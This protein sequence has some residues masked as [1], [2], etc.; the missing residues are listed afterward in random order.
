MSSR[1][2]K[3]PAP[4][5]K[6]VRQS[7]APRAK[8]KTARKDDR[9]V[10]VLSAQEVWFRVRAAWPGFE[11]MWE[12]GASAA[13]LDAAEARLGVAIP[14]R[15]R[16]LMTVSSGAMFPPGLQGSF[17]AEVCLAGVASWQRFSAETAQALDWDEATARDY[18]LI[19]ENVHG[20]DYGCY[21]ALH[22]G[23]GEVSAITL[24]IPEIAPLGTMDQWLLGL[25]P[26]APG[27]E[28]ARIYPAWLAESGE[29]FEDLVDS[30]RQYLGF[31]TLNLADRISRW[32]AIAPRFL[33]A[34]RRIPDP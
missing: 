29:S 25:R 28:P 2:K 34:V 16:E 1:T 27:G 6:A 10:A 30:H 7:K 17:A 18:V 3:T 8:S 12:P 32:D 26:G 31:S 24:N 13:E 9:V 33:D 20:V 14:R 23:T 5:K 21:V 11:F 19:G 15:V 22:A 4:A